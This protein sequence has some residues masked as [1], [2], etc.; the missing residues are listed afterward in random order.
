MYLECF[1]GAGEI[2]LRKL[3]YSIL[4]MVLQCRFNGAGEINLRKLARANDMCE[5][6]QASMGPE[7]LISGSD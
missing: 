5:S 2:N 4:S 3:L 7:K 1:N 6:E